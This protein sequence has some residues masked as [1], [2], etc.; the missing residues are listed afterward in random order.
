MTQQAL[1]PTV[2]RTFKSTMF[3]MI[4]SNK[5]ELLHLYNAVTRKIF[6]NAIEWR[7]EQ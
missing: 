2:N 5:E 7:R 1:M 6:W 4:F 3:T